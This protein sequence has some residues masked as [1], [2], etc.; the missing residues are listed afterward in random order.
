MRLQVRAFRLA[1]H[2]APEGRSRRSNLCEI[3]QRD[4]G[5]RRSVPLVAHGLIVAVLLVLCCSQLLQ[6]PEH[7]RQRRR[8]DGE[9]FEVRDAAP[10]GALQ[11]LQHARD[12][13][14]QRQQQVQVPCQCG[15]HTVRTGSCIGAEAPSVP[16]SN[17]AHS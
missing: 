9:V 16:A 14:I 15:N 1:E 6:L 7:V 8:D 4:S 5:P 11:R 2:L 17:I 10:L 12:V 13:G 3:C